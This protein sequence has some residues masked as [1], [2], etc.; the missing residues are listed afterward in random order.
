MLGCLGLYIVKKVRGK[1]LAP[2]S[3]LLVITGIAF[4]LSIFGLLQEI[5]NSQARSGDVNHHLGALF[6]EAAGK[7]S[8]A[9]DKNWMDTVT[10]EMLHDVLVTNQQYAGEK[11]TLDR[12]AIQNLYS[13]DSYAGQVHMQKVVAQLRASLAVDEKY[14]SIDPIIQKLDERVRAAKATEA[15]KQDYLKG[16]QIGVQ[17]SL[18][19]RTELIHKEE[20]WA[21]SAIDLYQF[22]IA[23]TPDYSIQ[24]NKVIIPDSKIRREFT[25][26]QAASISL[27]KD[28]VKM[29]N[30]M[31]QFRD[32]KLNQ[33]GLSSS[34]FTPAQLGKIK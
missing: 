31:R 13:L 28:L 21:K 27:H 10:R 25:A 7:D 29:R 4:P 12:S 16:V 8:G 22:L 24:E 26:Q 20:E 9:A 18:Q 6:K 1:T 15:E 33:A 17:Q 14:A 19:R 32:E 2:A 5:A 11:A 34:D 3:K 23:H 30:D